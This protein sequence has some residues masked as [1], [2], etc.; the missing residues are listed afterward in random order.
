MKNSAKKILSLFLAAAIV[1][2]ASLTCIYPVL[3]STPAN[4]LQ[5]GDFAEI[6]I[7]Q[8]VG[9]QPMDLYLIGKKTK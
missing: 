3:G 9:F 4:L 1:A 2:V 5:N 8:N 6:S 7:R